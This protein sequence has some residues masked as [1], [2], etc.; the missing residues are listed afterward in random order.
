[1]NS[2][3]AAFKAAQD[4]AIR[5]AAG[6]AAAMGGTLRLYTEREEDAPLP[7]IINGDDLITRLEET[8]CGVEADLVATVQWWSRKKTLDKG[9]Q[10]RAMGAILVGVLTSEA[11]AVAGWSVDLIT[12]QLE[13]YATDPDQSTRGRLII[14]YELSELIESEA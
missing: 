8:A 3:A 7:Y 4:A 2:P 11:F 13:H 12:L 9:A 6:L 14:E 5:A 1:M 10:A